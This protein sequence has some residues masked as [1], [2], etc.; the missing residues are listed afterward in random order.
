MNFEKTT[1]E[2][3]L[4]KDYTLKNVMK[5]IQ[6]AYEKGYDDATESANDSVER[7]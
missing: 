6:D 4:N 7:H 1:Q 5:L 2:F 3:M